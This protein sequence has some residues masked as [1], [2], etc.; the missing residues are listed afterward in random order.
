MIQRGREAVPHK[1]KDKQDHTYSI[2][3]I[4]KKALNNSVSCFKFRV[5]LEQLEEVFFCLLL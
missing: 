4:E 1:K 2:I 5:K 3:I